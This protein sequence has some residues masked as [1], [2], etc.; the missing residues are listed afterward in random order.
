MSGTR[1]ITHLGDY[2]SRNDG[3]YRIIWIDEEID[4]AIGCRVYDSG[5]DVDGPV[6]FR[7]DGEARN[8]SLAVDL[9]RSCD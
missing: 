7:L 3:L 6:G 9:I 4:A 5:I 8:V 1:V 2:L